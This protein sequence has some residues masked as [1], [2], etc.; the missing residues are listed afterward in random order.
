MVTGSADSVGMSAAR[1]ERIG[2]ERWLLRRLQRFTVS[3]HQHHVR[4]LLAIGAIREVGEDTYALVERGR[5]DPR[6]GLV[7]DDLSVVM[8]GLLA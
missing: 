2:P 5:Y 6:L 7:V 8:D 3:I 4:G 1:L